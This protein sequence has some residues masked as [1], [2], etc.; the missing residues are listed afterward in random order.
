MG[1]DMDIEDNFNEYLGISFDDNPDGTNTMTQKGLIQK[2]L[3]AAKMEDCNHNWTPA[4]QVA[5]GS[6]PDGEPP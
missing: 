6:N 3:K 5:L 4:H 2:T 1:F